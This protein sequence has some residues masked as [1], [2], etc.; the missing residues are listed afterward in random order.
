MPQLMTHIRITCILIILAFTSAC[1]ASQ[2][3]AALPTLAPTLAQPLVAQQATQV[4]RP[5]A[6]A[7][8]SNTPTPPT[9]LP[10]TPRP[11]RTLIPLPTPTSLVIESEPIPSSATPLATTALDQPP[12]ATATNVFTR[13]P[14]ATT[15]Q[16]GLSVDGRDIWGWRLGSGGATILL[17]GGVHTG[18]ESNTVMLLNEL[19]THYESTPADILP[20]ITLVLIPVLN[21]DGLLRGRTAEG[22]FNANNVDLNRNWGCEWSAEAYWQTRRVNP[23][24]RAFSEPETQALG[25]LIRDLRPA[26][27]IFYH[28]AATGV[29]S[30]DCEGGHGSDELA[31]VIG[32][33]AG[34]PYGQPF[35]AYR[36]TG[37][38]ANWVDGQGIPAV[39]LELS[40]TRETEFVRNLR[41]IQAVQQWVLGQVQP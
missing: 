41:A 14:G 13:V 12:T 7:L 33:A 4:L 10:G 35:T 21:P 37:T 9:L 27:A 1:Q 2:V 26:A 3:P 29:F 19:I 32:E 31:A 40:T 20:G 39:D 11:T 25:Q 15:F 30:G 34:Y 6:T 16:V 24:Q 17:V 28:S 22:R 38:A 5:V 18:F 36:V 8:P 23:G